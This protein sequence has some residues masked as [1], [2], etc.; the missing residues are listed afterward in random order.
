MKKLFSCLYF[1]PIRYLESTFC[2]FS[3]DLHTT[4][5]QTRP[6]M[7][8]YVA[9]LIF[10]EQSDIGFQLK[11]RNILWKFFRLNPESDQTDGLALYSFS[12]GNISFGICIHYYFVSLWSSQDITFFAGFLTISHWENLHKWSPHVC[13]K[14]E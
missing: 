14:L 3:T 1:V 5:I 9:N 6:A 7:Y 12:N 11:K 13:T 4:H 8:L 2:T 10:I